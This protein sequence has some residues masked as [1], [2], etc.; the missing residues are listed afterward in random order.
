MSTV[1][2]AHTDDGV[3]PAPARQAIPTRSSGI[4]ETLRT[5]SEERPGPTSTIE[6]VSA[7]AA[8]APGEADGIAGS[9]DDVREADC[10]CVAVCD[11]R[12][13]VAVAFDVADTGLADDVNDRDGLVLPLLDPDGLRGELVRDAVRDALPLADEETVRTTLRE[14]DTEA[15]RLADVDADF[16]RL[17]DTD[18]DGDAPARVAVTED[19]A[20]ENC[21]RERD[22]DTDLDAEMLRVRETLAPND[23]DGE[24]LCEREPGRLGLADGEAE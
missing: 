19:D 14:N 22:A 20:P 17:E 8:A 16:V 11:A 15:D 3:T 1:A 7:T 18:N 4:C 2:L 23:T 5:R 24:E 9:F 13:G 21:E 12:E 6:T 10:V